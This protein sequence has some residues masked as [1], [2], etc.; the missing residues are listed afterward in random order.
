MD[1]SEFSIFFY[2]FSST[3]PEYSSVSLDNILEFGDIIKMFFNFE[4]VITSSACSSLIK[5]SSYFLKEYVR[6]S[7]SS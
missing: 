4:A 5:A 2:D 1:I 6:H 7:G 3:V